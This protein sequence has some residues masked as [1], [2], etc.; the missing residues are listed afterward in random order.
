[1]R[2]RFIPLLMVVLL[3]LGSTAAFAESGS[4][5]RDNGKAGHKGVVVLHATE[6]STTA[7]TAD[8]TVLTEDDMEEQ[9]PPSAGD[10]FLLVDTLYLDEART[11]LAGR[12]DIE[13]TV[14]EF[15]G[16]SEEDFEQ[17]M[18]CHGVVTLDGAGTLAWQAALHF[19]AMAESEFDPEAPFATVAITGGTGEY[20]GAN[21]Q[22][23][24]FDTSPEDSVESLTRYE[25]KLTSGRR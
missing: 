19:S 14:T 17:H 11:E 13:C 25:V 23:Q 2:I 9:G 24:L 15:S 20:F 4:K 22:A 18:L 16:T 8:G 3:V 21:G 6:T 12:N 1:M 10:R 5:H 7:I